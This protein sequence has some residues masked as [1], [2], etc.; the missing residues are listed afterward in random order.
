MA[1]I[2]AARKL[3]QP[4][5]VFTRKVNQNL[6]DK[7][8][9]VAGYNYAQQ[10]ILG[11]TIDD[12]ELTINLET[13]ERMENDPTITKSKKVIVTNVLTD[14]MQM[15]PGATE[16]EVEAKEYDNY[17]EA[18]DFCQR[19]LGG[20][21]RPYREICEQILNNG[22]RYGHG[23]GE[24]EWAY[25]YD[26]PSP[27]PPKE[28]VLGKQPTKAAPPQGLFM[29]LMQRIGIYK[30]D[31][32]EAAEPAVNPLITKRRQKES[33][34][35]MIK[36]IKIK[37]RGAAQFVVDE[38]MTT[39]GL[40]P[41]LAQT[42]GV[43]GSRDIITR[44]KFLILTL[45]RQDEDPRGRS[46]YRPVFNWY[47]LKTQIPG[48]MLRG[49]IEEIVPKGVL[50]MP[51]NV[52]PFQYKVDSEGNYVMKDNQFVPIPAYD[53]YAQQM[54]DFRNGSVA[55]LP[56]GASLQ[57]YR[58]NA[59]DLENFDSL[60]TVID[61]Q[62]ENGLL[63]HQAEGPHQ[64]TLTKSTPKELLESMTFLLRWTLAVMTITDICK[65]ALAWNYGPEFVK[66][67]PFISFG[68]FV[69]RDWARDL[70]VISKAYFQGFIDDTQRAELCAWLNLPDPGPSRAEIQAQLDPTNGEPVMP[71]K[72]RPDK[73]DEN[74]NRNNGNSTEK[75]N[76]ANT[77][78]GTLDTL[79]HHG[80][81]FVGLAG[82][83]HTGRR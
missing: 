46:F 55:I 7:V 30:Q 82:N 5:G 10:R 43:V 59:S 28:E 37:P 69:R 79:G 26:R 42:G 11:T 9:P 80:K 73:Q 78:L 22:I 50:T 51:E 62:M 20:M 41:R 56:F 74:K 27:K 1:D 60:V 3:G 19:L 23:I 35:L 31:T 17:V 72:Q 71:N 66:Y 77:G 47:N 8:V 29:R 63:L 16:K 38:F 39:I 6:T 36:D 57:P 45:N 83:I 54:A 53:S 33:L 68:D 65:K 4:N 81:R 13:F 18:M 70:E 67:M 12:V 34:R 64:S 76:N 14:E 61:R 2:G 48:E 21:D 52:T 25:V 44:D 24:I 49:I 15:S 40:I 75:K 32:V 58:N